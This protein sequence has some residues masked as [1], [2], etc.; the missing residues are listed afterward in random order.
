MKYKKLFLIALNYYSSWLFRYLP[1]KYLRIN[2]L[3]LL[4]ATIGKSVNI[5]ADIFFHMQTPE[6][7]FRHLFI[8]DNVYIGPRSFIDLS[9]KVII[10]KDAAISMNCCILTHQDPGSLKKR[11]MAEYYPKK[12]SPVLIREGAYIGSNAVILAGIEIGKMSVVGAGAVVTK[13]VP[14]FT[15]IGGIPAKFIKKLGEQG[16]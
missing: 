13:N 2:V 11:P 3:K 10:E 14:S 16:Q 7:S 6:S 8:A 15:V 5:E 12:L 1:T 4:G 9:E